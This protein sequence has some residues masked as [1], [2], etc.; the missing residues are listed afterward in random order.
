MCMITNTLSYSLEPARMNQSPASNAR[1]CGGE[2][3]FHNRPGRAVKC[4]LNATLGWRRLGS[5][6]HGLRSMQKL[7]KTRDGKKKS[8]F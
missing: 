5:L 4:H 7:I 3:V 6:L 2:G 8:P 1:Q